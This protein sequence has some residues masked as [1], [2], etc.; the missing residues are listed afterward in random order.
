MNWAPIIHLSCTIQCN[1]QVSNKEQK[2]I[3]STICHK[4]K[5]LA[6]YLTTFYDSTGQKESSYEEL[7]KVQKTEMDKRE[8]EMSKSDLVQA[9]TKKE[10][11]AKKR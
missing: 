5:L 7:A 9:A 6:F 8:K 11:E 3:E 4:Y 1:G 10:D 2:Q